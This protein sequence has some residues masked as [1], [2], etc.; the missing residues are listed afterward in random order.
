MHGVL[1]LFAMQPDL[2]TLHFFLI[3]RGLAGLLCLHV[4]SP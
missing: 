2:K 3:Q 4:L 1:L